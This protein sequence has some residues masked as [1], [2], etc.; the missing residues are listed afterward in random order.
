MMKYNANVFDLVV[1]NV[2]TSSV[3]DLILNR[4]IFSEIVREGDYIRLYEASN[5]KRLSSSAESNAI[6]NAPY[7]VFQ[8]RSNTLQSVPRL[9]ISISKSVAEPLKLKPFA[10]N[11]FHVERISPDDGHIDFL[12]LSFRKQFLQRG[13]MYRFKDAVIGRTVHIGQNVAIDGI[14][15]QIQEIGFKGVPRI[16]GIV[17]KSTHVVF[18]SRSSRIIWLVQISKEVRKCYDSHY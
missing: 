15:A 5:N 14:T 17:C 10:A 16:S 8:I 11:K 1:H 2:T 4:D 13:N 12:E 3:E 9:E 18:R 6:E 7:L